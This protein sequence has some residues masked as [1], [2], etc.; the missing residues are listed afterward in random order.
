MCYFSGRLYTTEVQEKTKSVVFRLAVYSVTGLDTVTLLDT[1]D[2]KGQPTEPRICHQS[3]RVYLSCKSIGVYVVKYDGS[4]LVHIATLRHVGEPSGL[5]VV[6]PDTLYMCDKT[7]KTVCLVNVTQDRVT[8][9]LENPVKVGYSRPFNIAV[10]GDMVLVGYGSDELAIYRHGVPTPCK[11]PPKPQGLKDIT[12]LSTDH[13][14][15]FLL[16]DRISD[17]LYVLDISGNVTHT[18][19]IPGDRKPHDCT[20]VGG[21]TWVGCGNG[22]IIVM[23]PQ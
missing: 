7:S 8:T 5:A 21:Q 1:L 19:S 9:K 17:T 13:H 10:L 18:I 12:S 14:S 6:S 3:D 16:V 2:L 23:S 11:L 22:D 15:R 20:V 4:Q